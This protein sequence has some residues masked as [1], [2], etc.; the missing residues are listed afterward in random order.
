[1]LGINGMR[2]YMAIALEC[3]SVVVDTMSWRG[4]VTHGKE[5][6]RWIK[7]LYRKVLHRL[8]GPA[9]KWP[10]GS[11]EWLVNG[12]LHRLDGP[13]IE[14]ANGRKGWWVDGKLHRVN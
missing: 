9:V 4:M 8:D 7:T 2:W 6:D 10:D 5:E 13:A 1:M 14:Y 12:E 3:N 11:N